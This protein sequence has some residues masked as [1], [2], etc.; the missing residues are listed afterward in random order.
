MKNNSRQSQRHGLSSNLTMFKSGLLRNTSGSIASVNLFPRNV[1]IK[2]RYVSLQVSLLITVPI[3]NDL[4]R[5]D[6]LIV[7][8]FRQFC[9]K[10]LYNLSISHS[11]FDVYADEL[12]KKKI[13]K[14]M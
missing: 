10:K 8:K 3:I 13:K 14:T 4:Q 2:V 7:C 11:K 12:F 6:S 5:V 9:I 1:Q